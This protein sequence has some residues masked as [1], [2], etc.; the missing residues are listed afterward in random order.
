MQD[1]E[2]ISVDEAR[3][4]LA[5]TNNA[6]VVFGRTWR[7]SWAEGGERSRSRSPQAGPSRGP[8]RTARE[9]R[10]AELLRMLYI[11]LAEIMMLQEQ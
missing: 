11:L 9:R 4:A 10:L 2:F 3:S 8:S 1:V 6:A 5:R 7:A